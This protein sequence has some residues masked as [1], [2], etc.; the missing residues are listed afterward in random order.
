[1]S[2]HLSPSTPRQQVFSSK[3]TKEKSRK[4]VQA[5]RS[6]M[7][8]F[9]SHHSLLLEMP[10]SLTNGHSPNLPG[11]LFYN[12]SHG[13]QEAA[14]ASS[15]AASGGVAAMAAKESSS[16]VVKTSPQGCASPM[17]RKRKATEDNTT[18]SSGHSKVATNIHNQHCHFV[19]NIVSVALHEL[20]EILKCKLFLIKN[21]ILVTRNARRARAREGRQA[22]RRSRRR[23][24]LKM[25][26]PRVTFMSEQGEGRQQTAT[27]LQRGYTQPRVNPRSICH[28]KH[29]S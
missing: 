21:G 11:L 28:L 20:F 23:A 18:L 24:Q 1:M 4:K 29:F 7:A 12:Q 13:G 2:S 17:D 27:A 22:A 15:N 3:E 25:R 10:A 16:A 5:Q 19:C 26:L 6:S 8:D 9:S 14:S